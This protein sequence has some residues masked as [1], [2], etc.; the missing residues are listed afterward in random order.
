MQK[1]IYTADEEEPICERCDNFDAS[2][3]VCRK[4]GPEYWWARYSRTE[5]IKKD[6]I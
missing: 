1:Y 3:E 6:D 5:V 2:D 4:C